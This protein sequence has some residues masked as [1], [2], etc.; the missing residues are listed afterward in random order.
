MQYL[1]S[2][3]IRDF[4]REKRIETG[5]SLNGFAFD[6]DIDPAILCRIENKKQGIKLEILEKI[7]VAL[8][9]KMSEFFYEYEIE[10]DKSQKCAKLSGN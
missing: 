9:L 8:G 1:D 3:D 6:A 4:I 5:K 7:A 2:I 10:C